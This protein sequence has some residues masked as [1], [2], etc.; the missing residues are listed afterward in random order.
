MVF[1]SIGRPD[2][3]IAF[4]LKH[5]VPTDIFFRPSSRAV[6][7]DARFPQIARFQGLWDYWSSTGSWP[8]ICREP[9]LGWK[10]GTV[11]SASTPR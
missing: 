7:L 4:A 9:S 11:K 1:P 10:C 3:G 2:L 6:L 5:R 8:D